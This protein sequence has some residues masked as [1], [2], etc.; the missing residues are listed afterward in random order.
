MSDT[1]T[2]G[3]RIK[4]APRYIPEQS[5]PNSGKYLFAYHIVIENRGAETVQLLSRHWIITDGDGDRA[6]VKGEGVV[7]EKPRLAPGEQYEYTSAC[8]LATPVGTMQGSFH[9]VTGEGD[10]F[11][12]RID[13]F[14]LSL[15]GILH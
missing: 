13:P 8:P 11:D 4:V 1:T 10:R 7:G 15:P 12:A 3:I 9:M 5:D 14:R 6:E 2:R